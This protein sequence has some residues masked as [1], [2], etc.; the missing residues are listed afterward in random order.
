MQVTLT[1]NS[2]VLSE[3]SQMITLFYEPSARSPNHSKLSKL[4]ESKRPNVPWG[5]GWHTGEWLL[6]F[7]PLNQQLFIKQYHRL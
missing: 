5:Q 6:Q 3:D 1:P 7:H 2:F 4:I